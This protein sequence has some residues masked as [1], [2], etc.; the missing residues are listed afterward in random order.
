MEEKSTRMSKRWFSI[1]FTALVGLVLAANS[2]WAAAPV[3]L[4]G[5]LL[6]DPAPGK[7]VPYYRAASGVATLIGIE[8]VEAGGLMGSGAPGRDIAVLVTI[9]TKG[10]KHVQDFGLCLSPFDFGFLVL[11]ASA[12]TDAQQAEIS[13]R[14]GKARVLSVEQDK[15]PTEGYVTLKATAKFNSDNGTCGPSGDTGVNEGFAAGVSEPLATWAIL[16]NVGS[17]FFATE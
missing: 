15:I 7:L 16:L 10:S 6:G 9:F 14:F 12:L 17:G 1:V 11:Q 4:S 5:Y 13:Q 2:V 8:S 3:Q